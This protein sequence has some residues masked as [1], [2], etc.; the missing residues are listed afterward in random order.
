MPKPSFFERLFA[1]QQ[2]REPN[3]ISQTDI[4]LTLEGVKHV[5]VS[6]T[7]PDGV[8][9]WADDQE[10]LDYFYEKMKDEHAAK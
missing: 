6:R 10:T 8:V 3:S 4:S 5:G 7:F 2:K 9:L 1:I